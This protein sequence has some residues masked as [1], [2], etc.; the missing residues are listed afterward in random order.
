MCK[1]QLGALS[2][3]RRGIDIA[4]CKL[5]SSSLNSYP[6]PYPLTTGPSLC[7]RQPHNRYDAHSARAA[8]VMGEA[9]LRVLK[10]ALARSTQKLLGDVHDHA[11]ARGTD[12]VAVGL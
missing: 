7:P 10:L 12:G 5:A 4:S 6:F 2:R 9:D 11:D 8:E 3:A 1:C